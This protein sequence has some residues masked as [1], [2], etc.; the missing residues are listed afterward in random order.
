MAINQDVQ[1]LILYPGITKRVTLDVTQIVP[2]DT[3]ADEKLMLT[4]STTAYADNDARTAIQDMFVMY[5]YI[6]WI[7]SSGLVGIAGKFNLT[8]TSNRLGISMDAT[9]S[10]T[11]TYNN[12]AYYEIELDYNTDA[13]LKTGED[14]AIDMQ[15]KIRAIEC[16][17]ADKGFQLAYK[18]SDVVY[19]SG[20]FYI[21]S[22]SISS[23][24][25]GTER[26]SVSVA[27]AQTNDCTSVLGFDHPVSSEE[28]WGNTIAEAAI[29]VDY[30][31][32]TSTLMIGLGTGAVDGDSMYITD[33]TNYDY[34]TAI[35]VSGNT[36]TVP[37][38]AVNGFDGIKHSYA[39]ADGSYL[40]VL[41]KQDPDNK[42]NN[43]LSDMDGLLRY[44]AKCMINQIDFS[45]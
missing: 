43:Y 12:K 30:V 44:M 9:V 41:R 28:L 26:T 38:S 7:K 3:G 10:G 25:V 34:F 35:T 5:P 1:D 8:A 40:Q 36:V 16:V 17:E 15:E 21:T 19:T 18:N 2:T 27:P 32:G 33:G 20:K 24:Y 37:T 42:P 6:G 13:T 45:S 22:G 14:I 23:T 31:A 4:A 39:V 29:T 11:Y